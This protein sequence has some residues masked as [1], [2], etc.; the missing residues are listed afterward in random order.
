MP[1]RLN[2]DVPTIGGKPSRIEWPALRQG[3]TTCDS[4]GADLSSVES[5]EG[6]DDDGTGS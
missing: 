2:G 1:F 3:G 6:D 5:G 4:I